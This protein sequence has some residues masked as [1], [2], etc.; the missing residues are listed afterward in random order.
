[1]D[2]LNKI[3]DFLKSDIGSIIATCVIFGFICFVIYKILIGI[4]NRVSARV[5]PNSL[6]WNIL[7]QIIKIGMLLLF[8]INVVENVPA[9]SKVGTTLLACS[10][11]L[12]AAV[13]LASQDALGNAIDG[14][15]IS[16]FKPFAVGDRIRLNDKGIT[17][18]VADINLR[19]TTVKTFEN[20]LLMI[21]NSVMNSEIIENYN[22][23]D[24][25]I[26]AFVDVEVSYDADID[27]A[28]NILKELALSHPL[29]VDK[30]T[31]EEKDNGIEPVTISLRAFNASGVAL[32]M[33]VWSANIGDSF[34]L[35]SELREQI[36]KAFKEND[37]KIPYQTIE[38][39]RNN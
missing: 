4:L 37:I 20:N 6:H 25:R 21:P 3:L 22:I 24:Q 2:F 17:G 39:I 23:G 29:F 38:V 9:L 26:V 10:S 15:L 31:D 28:K 11:V 14:L 36:L 16:L 30:R 5:N 32:R 35:C 13:G 7:K 27:L 18:T 33:P 8:I 34:K 19:Y 12:A 1:M